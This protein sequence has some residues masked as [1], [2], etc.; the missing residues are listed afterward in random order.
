MKST[1]IPILSS[2][3][4]YNKGGSKY[5]EEGRKLFGT[6]GTEAKNERF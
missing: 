4:T 2:V 3:F 1:I 6:N 5:I